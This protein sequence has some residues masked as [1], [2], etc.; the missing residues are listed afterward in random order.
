[1]FCHWQQL[2]NRWADIAKLVGRSENWVKNYC[3]KLLKHEEIYSEDEKVEDRIGR[4]IE[5]L[6]SRIESSSNIAAD[7]PSIADDINGEELSNE[8]FVTAREDIKDTPSKSTEVISSQEGVD[9][10]E[11]KFEEEMSAEGEKMDVEEF[12]SGENSPM[13]AESEDKLGNSLYLS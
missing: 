2:G 5:R 10:M 9:E 13:E 12:E 3:R 8:N 1:M 6:K 11:L 7:L 4:L